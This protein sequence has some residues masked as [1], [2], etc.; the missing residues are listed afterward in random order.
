M[1]AG[2]ISN[3]RRGNGKSS[4]VTHSARQGANIRGVA[5]ATP[6]DID[7]ALGLRDATE[8]RELFPRRLNGLH[9]VWELGETC[10]AGSFVRSSESGRLGRQR[11]IDRGAHFAQY[12]QHPL[13]LL[14]T[15]R[16]DQI[17]A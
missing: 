14:L 3:S 7:D 16:P 5:T 8:V 1:D 9:L 2:P 11:N 17:C 4:F 6:A 10:E 13:R 12:G 15:V